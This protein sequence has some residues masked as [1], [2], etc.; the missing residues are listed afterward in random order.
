MPPA[1]WSWGVAR[2][3]PGSGWA[4]GRSKVMLEEPPVFKRMGIPEFSLFFQSWILL[5]MPLRKES[6]RLWH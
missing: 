4:V 2:S 1:S 3:V 5:T 6:R